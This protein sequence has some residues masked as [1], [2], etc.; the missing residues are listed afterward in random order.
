MRTPIRIAVLCLLAWTAACSDITTPTEPPA[1]VTEAP[2]AN[3][4]TDLRDALETAR[5]AALGKLLFEDTDLSLNKNQACA[6]CHDADW[7]FTGPDPLNAGQ[8]SVF[9][10]SE[11]GRFGNRRPPSA[12]YATLSPVFHFDT[13]EGIWF[14]GNF[15]NGRATGEILGNPAADQALAPFLNPAEQALPDMACVVYRVRHARYLPIYRRSFGWAIHRIDFPENADELCKVEGTTLPLTAA[16]RAAAQE[17]YYNVARAIADFEDS[18]IVNRFTSKFDY[19]RAGLAR[20]SRREQRGLEL[21]EGKAMCNACHPSEGRHALFT[22]FSFDNIGIPANPANPALLAEGFVDE[23]LGETLRNRGEPAAVWQPEI[24]KQ[25]V[26]TLRNMDKRPYGVAKT[27]MHNG[28]LR[29]VEEVVHF[30][31]TRDVLPACASPSDPGKG[32]TCWPAPEVTVNVN[33]DELGD[34]G[35]TADEEADLV[36]FLRTLSDGWRGRR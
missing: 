9:E 25:K 12:A 13:D 4:I 5:N 27:F 10:G 36:A 34:L 3:L 7:G 14:G 33:V 18:R 22:D 2:D 28:A 20:L 21:F 8:G 35:L 32:V 29:T 16:D 11:A 26:P 19:F 6:S 24:G 31:N 23:G 15:W 17:E 1:D 30:Y